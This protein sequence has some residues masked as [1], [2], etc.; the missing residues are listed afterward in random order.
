ML[1][2]YLCIKYPGVRVVRDVFFSYVDYS[3]VEN[4][5]LFDNIVRPLYKNLNFFVSL[6]LPLD[7]NFYDSFYRDFYYLF[8]GDLHDSLCWSFYD[9]LYYLVFF[10]HSLNRH[11]YIHINGHI[12]VRII[13]LWNF[14]Y[15]L[16][17]L[18]FFNVLDLL[19]LSDSRAS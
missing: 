5:V 9:G 12:Y 6:Y 7:R 19:L 4:D 18:I 11:I 1:V 16:N 14:L 8:N 2:V 13:R 15:D 3:I 17:N 10:N